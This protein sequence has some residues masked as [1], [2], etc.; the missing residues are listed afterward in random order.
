MYF[1]A[2]FFILKGKVHHQTRSIET[3]GVDD[4]VARLLV[5]WCLLY[6]LF[7]RCIA[8]AVTMLFNMRRGF[9]NYEGLLFRFS[10]FVQ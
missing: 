3:F 6:L 5:G 7:P 10:P 4:S 1:L 9:T 2:S 8:S